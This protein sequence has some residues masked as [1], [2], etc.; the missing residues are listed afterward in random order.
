MGRVG[1]Q[2][3]EGGAEAHRLPPQHYML[4]QLETKGLGRVNLQWGCM[5]VSVLMYERVR[6][7]TL[8]RS[9]RGQSCCRGCRRFAGTGQPGVQ[10]V[11]V[12]C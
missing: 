5:G 12:V 6:V 2:P 3:L 7:R 9:A 4:E 10:K 1:R 11:H 8:R